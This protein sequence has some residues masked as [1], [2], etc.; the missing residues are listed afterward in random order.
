MNCDELRDQYELYALGALDPEERA[1]LDAH[2]RREGD[3]CVDGGRPPGPR[4]PG[5]HG[6]DLLRSLLL[7]RRRLLHDHHEQA[8][9]EG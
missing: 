8:Q 4:V 1:E 7:R 9:L 5:T 2:L 3:P 6:G